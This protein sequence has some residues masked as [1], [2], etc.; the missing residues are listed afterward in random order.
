MKKCKNCNVK[1]TDDKK[2]CKTCGEPL[3]EINEF[4]S[5]EVTQ[6]ALFEFSKWFKKNLKTF[7]GLLLMVFI[8]YAIY[9]I[10]LRHDPIKDA[11]KIALAHCDCFEKYNEELIKINQNWL[12]SFN[13][14]NIKNYQDAIV[15]L[16]PYKDQARVQ[17]S[18]CNENV[19]SKINDMKARYNS[20]GENLKKFFASIPPSNTC[21]PKNEDKL[22]IMEKEVQEKLT[23][24]V[25][26]DQHEMRKSDIEEQIKHVQ[27]PNQI[28]HFPQSSK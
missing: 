17:F 12:A 20:N 5:I 21:I 2:F 26:K 10:V 15:K 3:I 19:L 13:S 4:D 8:F 7:A 9:Y 16:M 18:K 6:K 25:E 1:Y 11:N 27:D 28:P 22:V 23:S 24:I 14:N